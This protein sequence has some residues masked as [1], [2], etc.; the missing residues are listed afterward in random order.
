VLGHKS[1]GPFQKKNDPL[2]ELTHSMSKDS[3]DAMDMFGMYQTSN[4]I[5]HG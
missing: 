4:Q 3:N 5:A 2:M 1:S